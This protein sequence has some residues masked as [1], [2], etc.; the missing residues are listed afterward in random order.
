MKTFKEK[1]TFK[2]RLKK[3]TEILKKFP[4]RIPIIVEQGKNSN[5]PKLDK[6]KY[7][8]PKDLTIG[9]FKYV[10]RKRIKLQPEKSL[11]LFIN[12][13][14]PPI[15]QLMSQIYQQHKSKCGFIYITIMDQNTFG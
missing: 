6:F 11:F 9:Q 7:L 10:L 12:N 1:F 5:L 14:I 3:S 2:E 4:D 8:I 15:S 13:N